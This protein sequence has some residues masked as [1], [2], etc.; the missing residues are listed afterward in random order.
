MTVAL[1]A[2]HIRLVTE[3]TVDY[4]LQR[5]FLRDVAIRS[6]CIVSP[7]IDTLEGSRFTLRDL[8][9][10]I[11]RECIPTYVVTRSPSEPYHEE[12]IA[13]LAC[14]DW[15]EIRFNESVHAKVYVT[16]VIPESES[17]A[18]FGSGNLTSR[19]IADNIEVGMLIVARGQGRLLVDELYYWANNRLRVLDQSRLYQ[20]IRAKRRRLWVLQRLKTGFA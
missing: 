19:S 6:L 10:K 16:S 1:E 13:I 17:F 4:F 12:A 8:S 11:E 5:F 18:L 15:I 20:R 7:F 3:R 9:E 2:R 14:N